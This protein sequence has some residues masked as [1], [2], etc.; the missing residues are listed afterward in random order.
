MVSDVQDAQADGI[1]LRHDSAPCVYIYGSNGSTILASDQQSLTWPKCD[2][3]VGKHRN[4]RAERGIGAAGG[5][6]VIL[7]TATGA[8]M[9]A[10]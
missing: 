7:A 8:C 4:R 10:T 1:Q 9:H 2:A 5:A 3:S 6:V